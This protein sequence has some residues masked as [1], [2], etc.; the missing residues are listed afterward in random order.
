[1]GWASGSPE[2]AGLP[3]PLPLPLLLDGHVDHAAPLGPGA[4]VVADLGVSQQVLEDEPGVGGALTD[5]A[6][7][8]DLLV[9]GDALA[10]IEGPQFV[11]GLEGAV[12]A[13]GLAPGDVLGARNV[14]HALGGLWQTGRRHDLA[15]V[16]W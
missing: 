16:L 7:G 14:A 13:Y 4:V 3:R 12:L 2:P 6:V 9:G 1:M 5:A 8:D 15:V 11:D 10:L